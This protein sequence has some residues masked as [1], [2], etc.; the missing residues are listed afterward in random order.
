V[1]FAFM[2]EELKVQREDS[3]LTGSALFL[4]HA[5]AGKEEEEGGERGGERERE[6]GGKGRARRGGGGEGR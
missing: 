1:V 3:C 4:A 2:K 5:I 6:R